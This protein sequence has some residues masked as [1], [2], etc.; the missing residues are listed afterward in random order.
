MAA[1]HGKEDTIKLLLSHKADTTR[2]GGVRVRHS[3]YYS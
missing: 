3:N 2:Q 1:A